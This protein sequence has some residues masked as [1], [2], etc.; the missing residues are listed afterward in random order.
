MKKFKEKR[1]QQVVRNHYPQPGKPLLPQYLRQ[2]GSQYPF[3]I[4]AKNI[5]RH[6]KG[7]DHVK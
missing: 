1:G 2:T 4:L 5:V 6:L 7:T 3:N